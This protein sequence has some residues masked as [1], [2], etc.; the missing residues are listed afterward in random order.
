MPDRV[1]GKAAFVT[2][3]ARGLGRGHTVRLPDLG[4]P[5]VG[6]AREAF[7]ASGEARNFT[8]VTLPVDRGTVI[9]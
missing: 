9:K 1:K 7:L 4:Y 8:G 3:A 5:T 6:D 2:G